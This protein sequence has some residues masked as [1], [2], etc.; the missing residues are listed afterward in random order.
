MIDATPDFREQLRML[1]AIEPPRSS[2]GLDGIFLSH[3]HIGHYTG[4]MFIGHESIG[5]KGVPV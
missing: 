2:P 3:A 5:A 1:D 4:L